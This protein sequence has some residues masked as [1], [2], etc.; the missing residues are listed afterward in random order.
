SMLACKFILAR[1]V[2]AS[3]QLAV[4]RVASMPTLTISRKESGRTV[5][6]ILRWRLRL[7]GAQARRLV[8]AL[9][10][11]L[12][13]AVCRDAARRVRAGQ[14]LQVREERQAAPP[15]KEGGP[16]ICFVD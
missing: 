15:R 4:S 10:I 1:S 11:R 2:T 13:G 3:F 6:E 7:S 5:L 16:V 12:D 9:Q 14:R 8:Q